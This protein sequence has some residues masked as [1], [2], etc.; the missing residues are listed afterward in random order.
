M[1]PTISCEHFFPDPQK[2]VNYA[3]TLEYFPA[4]ANQFPSSDRDWET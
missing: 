2:I 4:E 3:E 1:F